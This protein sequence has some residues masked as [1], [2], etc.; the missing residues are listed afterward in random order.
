MFL[1]GVTVFQLSD[2]P[3]TFTLPKGNYQFSFNFYNGGSITGQFLVGIFDS[4]TVGFSLDTKGVIGDGNVT[5]S[6]PN[7]MTTILLYDDGMKY[8]SI[9]IGYNPQWFGAYGPAKGA[10]LVFGWQF[11]QFL[12]NPDF[13]FFGPAVGYDPFVKE[14]PFI[15]LF[16]AVS[17]PLGA[18]FL[19]S[20][21]IDNV[22]VNQPSVAFL[23]FKIL[24]RVAD[25]LDIELHFQRFAPWYPPYV[26]PSRIFRV[27]YEASF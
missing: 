23:N 19:L 22:G 3:T 8:P 13:I 24:F 5:V 2:V 14:P 18:N 25:N 26:V 1:L 17:V 9:A 11:A 4:W 7:V 10:F 12:D 15:H 16:A 6:R 20:A 21:E 27:A